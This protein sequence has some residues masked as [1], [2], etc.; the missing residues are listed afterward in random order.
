M[1]SGARAGRAAAATRER[2]AAKVP[3]RAPR[4]TAIGG[5]GQTAWAARASEAAS[6][7]K[8][9]P[10]L[11]PI[12]PAL[13]ATLRALRARPSATRPWAMGPPAFT[14]PPEGPAMATALPTRM[15]AIASGL[16]AV[17]TAL[18]ASTGT[19][20]RSRRRIVVGP[21]TTTAT[22]TPGYPEVAAG[23]GPGP[24]TSQ[25]AIA[26]SATPVGAVGSITAAPPTLA[27]GVAAMT[28]KSA[29]LQVLITT[30]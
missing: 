12:P 22:A 5:S 26:G 7:S 13:R 16:A 1:G 25:A 19:T 2:A 21:A 15:R 20:T 3:P 23:T 10:P 4:S 6:E 27:T 17:A 9:A 30:G 18:E 8:A 11:S 28:A 14:P 29:S 24:S